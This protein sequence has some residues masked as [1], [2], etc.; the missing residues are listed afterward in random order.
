MGN[1]VSMASITDVFSTVGTAVS[2]YQADVASVMALARDP[3]SIIQSI[4]I[5]GAYTPTIVIPRPLPG[6]QQGP[7]PP[8]GTPPPQPNWLL[9]LLK[10]QIQVNLAPPLPPITLAMYGTPGPTRWT[11]VKVGGI[12]A[13]MFIGYF[14]FRGVACTS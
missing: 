10:P 3:G 5:S 2:T 11:W 13:A 6:G 4:V 14:T 12:V 9:N 7:P 8:P 1:N